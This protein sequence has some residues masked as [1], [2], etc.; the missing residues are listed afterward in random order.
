MT[1]NTKINPHPDAV[2]GKDSAVN[3]TLLE[4]VERLQHADIS[5]LTPG[6]QSTLSRAVSAAARRLVEDHA[7]LTEEREAVTLERNQLATKRVEIEA[8]EASVV[9][10]ET[11]LGLHPAPKRNRFHFWK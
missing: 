2:F 10:R 9:A 11:L 7:K 3:D 6:Q 5:A 1:F 4:L 8:R